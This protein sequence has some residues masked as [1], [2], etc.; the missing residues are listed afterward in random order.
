MPPGESLYTIRLRRQDR[1]RKPR[2]FI[3]LTHRGAPHKR[4]VPY[5]RFL[6]EKQN[7]P[8]PEGFRVFMRIEN[9]DR[10]PT[11]DQLFID[12]ADS[13]SLK[14]TD[15]QYLKR[16]A[17]SRAKANRLRHR[18][19]RGVLRADYWYLVVEAARAIVWA[20][21]RR[22]RALIANWPVSKVQKLLIDNQVKCEFTLELTYVKGN[23]IELNAGADGK[24]EGFL[25]VIPDDR[26]APR[27]R[28]K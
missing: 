11:I 12:R 7:G 5:A 2:W 14:K 17:R 3:K 18:I 20:P 9:L 10:P 23:V 1:N 24:Y 22:R 16:R 15:R 6:W 26:R 25:R 4:W 21:S 13:R 27:K 28:S 8:V 19:D